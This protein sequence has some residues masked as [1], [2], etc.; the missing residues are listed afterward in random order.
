MEGFPSEADMLIHIVQDTSSLTQCLPGD[1]RVLFEVQ[2]AVGIPD[3]ILIAFNEYELAAR[4]GLGLSPVVDP[5]GV[6]V[7]TALSVQ[8][9][10]NRGKASYTSE[11]LALLTGLTRGYLCAVLGRLEAAGHVIKLGRGRW[12]ATHPFHPL[13]DYV[14]SVE[15]KRVDWRTGLW[16]AHRQAT[17]YTWLVMDVTKSAS[18]ITR[19][20][21]FSK[22][23]V[24]LAT[25][26]VT[27]ELR[28]IVPAVMRRPSLVRRRLL[29]ERAADLFLSGKVSGPLNPVFGRHLSATTGV[30]PRLQ[31]ASAR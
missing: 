11:R 31:G 19:A 29:I 1:F 25:L 23:K 18:T 6:A 10:D 9:S 27:S 30:D 16:Q 8:Y 14:I 13:A 26:S 15:T 28:V 3:L 21:K 5:A 2:S 4:K 20:E 17:D 12:T 24:G 7:L 22:Y